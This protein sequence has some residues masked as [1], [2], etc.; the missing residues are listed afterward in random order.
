MKLTDITTAIFVKNLRRRPD[1]LEHMTN[2]MASIETPF[3]LL[4]AVD[5]RGTLKDAIWWNAQNGLQIVRYAK[6]AGLSSVISL[7]DDC[8]FVDNFNERLT[9]L[10]PYIPGDWDMVSFGDVLDKAVQIHPGI[11]HTHRSWGGHATLI[12][13]TVYDRLLE[14]IT[15]DIYSDEEVN[16]KLK[17]SINY[18]VFSPSLVTQLDGFSDLK[19][20]YVNNGFFK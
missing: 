6:A 17:H 1:R 10:W 16:L 9:E 8:V 15:G 18:Y 7:D 14:C 12:R 2:Q 4:D 19:N 5:D 3:T 13:N 11:V 20:R